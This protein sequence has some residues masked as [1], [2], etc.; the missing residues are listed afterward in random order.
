[1]TDVEDGVEQPRRRMGRARRQDVGRAVAHVPAVF[2]RVRRGVGREVVVHGVQQFV[3]GGARG[4]PVSRSVAADAT[5]GIALEEDERHPSRAAR[6][7][8]ARGSTADA[9]SRGAV[10]VHEVLLVGVA[11]TVRGEVVTDAKAEVVAAVRFVDAAVE[12]QRHTRDV[13]AAELGGAVGKR[14]EVEARRTELVL[15]APPGVDARQIAHDRASHVSEPVRRVRGVRVDDVH[16]FPDDQV[17]PVFGRFVRT[18]PRIRKG[19][20]PGRGHGYEHAGGDDCEQQR[21]APTDH[22]F[23]P[24]CP[25]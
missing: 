5:A 16:L 2:A 1:M 22:K 12:G 8:A 21:H 14:R 17:G 23:L 25:P 3:R 24:E 20:R 19:R 7:R 15:R 10:V 11:Q 9:S 18:A 4:P 13:D 6:V